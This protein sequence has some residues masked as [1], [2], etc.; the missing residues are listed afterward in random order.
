MVVDEQVVAYQEEY[1]Q[2]FKGEVFAEIIA[3]SEGTSSE[4]VADLMMDTTNGDTAMFMMVTVMNDNP[5]VLGQVMNSFADENF[6]IFEHIE[7]TTNY[8]DENIIEIDESLVIDDT[9]SSETDIS[10]SYLTS[11]SEV[12]AIEIIKLSI[13]ERKALNEKKKAE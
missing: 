3:H 2:N 12:G 4:I 10:K 11:S 6:D 7:E 9:I 5:E 1:F 8:E 13:C